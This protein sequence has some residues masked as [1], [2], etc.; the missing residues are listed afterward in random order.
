MDALLSS[1]VFGIISL[2]VLL[3][4]SKKVNFSKITM[5][6]GNFVNRRNNR[7]VDIEK[8]IQSKKDPIQAKILSRFFKSGKGQYGEGDI[9][10][11]ITFLL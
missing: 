11:G 5:T 2:K 10:L 1:F 3:D 7:M 8:E 6:F 4:F 9:F